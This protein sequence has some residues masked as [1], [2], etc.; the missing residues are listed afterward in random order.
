MIWQALL[1]TGKI[2]HVMHSILV[3]HLN[4]WEMVLNCNITFFSCR[5][6]Q[7]VLHFDFFH[8]VEVV[9]FSI[10]VFFLHVLSISPS[11]SILVHD[12]SV[13]FYLVRTFLLHIPTL[14]TIFCTADFSSF[15]LQLI[16]AGWNHL[17][18]HS[19]HFYV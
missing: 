14:Q 8:Y 17:S 1:T 5:N 13:P 7:V 3:S 6:L 2:H 4:L 19:F 11:C 18:I 16:F 9:Y 15:F 10:V 12:F